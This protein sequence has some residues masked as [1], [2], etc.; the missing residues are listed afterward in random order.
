MRIVI[1]VASRRPVPTTATIIVV[2]GAL[3]N[4][5]D[6]TNSTDESVYNA[7]PPLP[8]PQTDGAKI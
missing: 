3:T 7:N 1:N 6:A 8:P 2:I 5:P 4:N